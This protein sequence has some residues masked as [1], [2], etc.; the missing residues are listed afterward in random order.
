MCGSHVGTCYR[1]PTPGIHSQPGSSPLLPP[2]CLSFWSQLCLE[3]D[4][5]HYQED[6]GKALPLTVDGEKEVKRCT[7]S[8]RF[9]E[10][11]FIIFWA[12]LVMSIPGPLTPRRKWA[13]F[14]Q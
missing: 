14:E 5:L 2:P 9:G 7:E 6:A 1:F 3:G 8:S 13:G 10:N 11:P 4:R 12:P